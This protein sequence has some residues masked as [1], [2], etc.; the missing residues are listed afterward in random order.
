MK[1]LIACEESQ[2]VCTA[3]RRHGHEA[4]SADLQECSGGHPEWHIQGDVLE[5]LDDGWDMMIAHPECKYLC[6]SGARWFEDERYPNREQDWVDGVAFFKA[7]QNAPI[8]RIAIENSEP[9]GRTVQQVGRY[10]QIVQPYHFGQPTTKGCFLWLKNL[11]KLIHTHTFDDY[12]D[13]KAE[14][15]HMAPSP[16]RSKLRS[17]FPAV[18]AEAM[19]RQWGNGEIPGFKDGLFGEK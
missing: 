1:V 11:P 15:H 7:L 14:V 10:S 16:E 5:I 18:I 17:K 4:Y 13:I 8:D 2:A 19:A 9:L 3:F 6:L 12:E